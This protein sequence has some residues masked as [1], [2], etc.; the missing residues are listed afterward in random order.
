MNLALT[1]G[2]VAGL[3]HPALEARLEA[4]PG[5]CCVALRRPAR[6][7]QGTAAG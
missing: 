4:T 2:L 3:G 1:A 6:Q 7:A 5:M